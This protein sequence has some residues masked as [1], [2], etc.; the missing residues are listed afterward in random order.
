VIINNEAVAMANIPYPE[1]QSTYAIYVKGILDQRW[2]DWFDGFSISYP[3]EDE[4]LL[5]GEV[6]DQAALHGLL[7]TLRDLNLPILAVQK[8]E[9]P[10][11]NKIL[12]GRSPL[13]KDKTV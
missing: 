2:S 12:S 13:D 6:I 11:D 9:I 3:A 8:V 4:T 1:D 5:T 10:L 7:A